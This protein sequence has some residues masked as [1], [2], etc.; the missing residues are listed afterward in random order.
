MSKLQV[1]QV[2][3]TTDGK[4]HGNKADAE[5]HQKGL[6]LQ[7]QLNAFFKKFNISKVQAGGL[8]KI[9]PAYVSWT[10]SESFADDVAAAEAEAKEAAEKAAAEAQAAKDAET[11]KLAAQG[12]AA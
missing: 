11:A 9:I 10:E 5:A 8:R 1:S 2:F 12:P 3:T 7:H 4:P 6:D